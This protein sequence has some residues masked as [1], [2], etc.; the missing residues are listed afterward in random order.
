MRVGGVVEDI[1]VSGALKDDHTHGKFLDIRL[2][3]SVEEVSYEKRLAC[4]I[5]KLRA[6]GFTSSAAD[7]NL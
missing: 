5:P 3:R 4:F 2:V 1:G 6:D 7:L